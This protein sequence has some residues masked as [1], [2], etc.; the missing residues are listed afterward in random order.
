MFDVVVSIMTLVALTLIAVWWFRPDLRGWM[1]EP[2]Y[3]MLSREKLFR[4]SKD[5]E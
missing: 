2:K 1:E 3:R 4:K 5:Q